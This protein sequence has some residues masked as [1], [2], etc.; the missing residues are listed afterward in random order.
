M[1]D[2]YLANVT[3]SN[4]LGP[5]QVLPLSLAIALAVS[6]RI[7]GTDH[8][9]HLFLHGQVNALLGY[10]NNRP[11]LAYAGTENNVDNFW[12]RHNIDLNCIKSSRYK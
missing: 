11:P 7:E 4:Y 6:G 2:A 1:L 9:D 8:T 3:A 5:H 10:E 12:I